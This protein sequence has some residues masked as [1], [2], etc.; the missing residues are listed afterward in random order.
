MHAGIGDEHTHAGRR[1]AALRAYAQSFAQ[2]PSL[3]T[4]KAVVRT[5]VT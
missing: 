1:G 5:L 3:R 2:A 4:A